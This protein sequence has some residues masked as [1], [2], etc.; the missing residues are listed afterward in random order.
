MIFLKKIYVI[1]E[2]LLKVALKRL[3]TLVVCVAL[4]GLLAVI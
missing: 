4:R 3:G 2:L 1:V